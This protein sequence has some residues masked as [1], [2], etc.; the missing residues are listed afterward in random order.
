MSNS[1]TPWSAG[2]YEH[3]VVSGCRVWLLM[4]SNNRWLSRRVDGLIIVPCKV[5]QKYQLGKCRYFLSSNASELNITVL[6]PGVKRPERGFPHLLLGW[7]A[8][9]RP[10]S[11][12]DLCYYRG[13]VW[14]PDPIVL[15]SHLMLRLWLP[16]SSPQHFRSLVASMASCVSSRTVKAF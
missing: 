14:A 6:L 10:A 7:L 4:T 9:L 1:R 11:S 16:A 13:P 8:A 12:I 2:T 5:W 3:L 15:I